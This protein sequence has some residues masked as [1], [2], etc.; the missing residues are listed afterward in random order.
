MTYQAKRKNDENK[1]CW[2]QTLLPAAGERE[3]PEFPRAEQVMQGS[4]SAERGKDERHGIEQQVQPTTRA[5][6]VW[7]HNTAFLFYIYMHMLTRRELVCFT[8]AAGL[9]CRNH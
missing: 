8:P 4:P 9:E 1:E 3:D 6:G 7:M 5:Q 2:S